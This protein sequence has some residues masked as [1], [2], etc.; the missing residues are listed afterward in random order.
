V[1]P[2]GEDASDSFPSVGKN[3]SFGSARGNSKAL[4]WTFLWTF[5]RWNPAK[6]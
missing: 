5:Y 4:G 3:S 1:A 6:P 2:S